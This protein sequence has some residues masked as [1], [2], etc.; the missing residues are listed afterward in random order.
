[1]VFFY[2]DGFGIECLTKVDL[3]LNKE[4]KPSLSLS[5]FQ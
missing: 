2:K 5:L 1:M 3:Q 4:A